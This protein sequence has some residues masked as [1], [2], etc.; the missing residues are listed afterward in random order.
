MSTTPLLEIR[1]LAINFDTETGVVE[2]V[3]GISMTLGEGE[4]L[5]VVGESGSGKS[6]TGLALTKLLPE[7][8]VVYKSGE[9]LFKGQDIL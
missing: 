3:K 6:V 1:N 4:T 7:P 8:P 2:A 5:A 9:I